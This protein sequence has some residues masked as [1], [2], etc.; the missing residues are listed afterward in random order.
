[1]PNHCMNDVTLKCHSEEVAVKMKELLAGK[2]S[3]FDFNSLVPEPQELLESRLKIISVEELR[4]LF[5]HD[6]WYDWRYSN[7]GTKWN[8]YYCELDDSQIRQG[9]LVYRFSTAWAPPEGIC[10][11]LLE[12]I[13]EHELKV[14]VDWFYHEAGNGIRGQLEEEV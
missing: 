10:K 7:W 8:S 13:R 1:M 5:G 4:K 11:A 12:H 6:N 9:I 14:E 2:E 3:L